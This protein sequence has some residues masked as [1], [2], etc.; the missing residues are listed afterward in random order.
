MTDAPAIVTE[1]FQDYD[2]HVEALE[3]ADIRCTLKRLERPLWKKTSICL[4]GGTHVQAAAEGC[5]D[6]VQGCAPSD[7]YVVMALKKYRFVANGIETPLGSVFLMPP[8]SEFLLS[9]PLS[10]EWLSVF[11]PT[12]VLRSAL[13]DIDLAGQDARNARV[14]DIG[15]SK[16]SRLWLLIERYIHYASTAPQWIAG[17]KALA[18]F[19]HDLLMELKQVCVPARPATAPTRGG[20]PETIDKDVITTAIDCVENRPDAMMTIPELVQVTGLSE[21]SLRAG[22][23]R[24][25]G[26]SPSQYTR[27]RLLNRAR[28]RLTESTPGEVTVTQVAGGLGFWDVGRFAARYREAFGELP[29]ETLRE[30]GKRAICRRVQPTTFFRERKPVWSP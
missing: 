14:I 18:S 30:G 12:P 26:V 9:L 11:I 15:T 28:Q 22:F 13:P 4:P 5:S 7:G 23:G 25:V 10:Q 3:D 20:R 6:I 1:V 27:L 29:S 19:E 24:F 16:T 8:G 2:A 21:R 17:K